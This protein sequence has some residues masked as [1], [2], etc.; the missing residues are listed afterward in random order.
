MPYFEIALCIVGMSLYFNAG[1]M[2]VRG[3]A[4]DRSVLWGSVSLLVSISVF[5]AGGGWLAWALAQ[6]G[7]MFAIALIR[8]WLDRE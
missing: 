2:E 7:L 4:P 1:K 6:V 8:V 3:G 5:A